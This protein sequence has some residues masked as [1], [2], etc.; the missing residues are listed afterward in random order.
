MVLFSVLLD[1]FSK[2]LV[3]DFLSEMKSVSIFRYFSLTLV[4]NTG[5][6]FGILN[7]L[8]VRIFI[9]TAS[10][11]IG[12][13]IIISIIRYG[14]DKQMIIA[15]G[16]VEG[17]IIGNLIDRIRIGAVIDFINFHFWPVFNLAD[18]F[19]VTGVVIIFF[20]HFKGG[21]YAPRVF[22]DR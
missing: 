14:K 16:L 18:A 20:H 6:C 13:A 12:I 22:E 15:S 4:K 10:F 2:Y 11:I 19:I 9:I 5:I 17:G 3:V 21:K 1:Q 7:N 8:N